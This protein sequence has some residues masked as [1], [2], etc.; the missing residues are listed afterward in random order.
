MLKV[1]F[2][3]SPHCPNSGP[4][5]AFSGGTAAVGSFFPPTHTYLYTVPTN[6]FYFDHPS[7]APKGHSLKTSGIEYL[8]IHTNMDSVQQDPS[9]LLQLLLLRDMPNRLVYQIHT[10]EAI[11]GAHNLQKSI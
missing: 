6:L 5:Q 10:H 9:S 3:P 1:C 4:L 8:K 11:S 2:P 7:E